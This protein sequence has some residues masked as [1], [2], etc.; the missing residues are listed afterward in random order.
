MQRVVSGKRGD[1]KVQ[2]CMRSRSEWWA[3]K[4]LQRSAHRVRWEQ[5]TTDKVINWSIYCICRLLGYMPVALSRAYLLS[6]TRPAHDSL[7]GAKM[8]WRDIC[9]TTKR[10]TGEGCWTFN[11]ALTKHNLQEFFRWK[12]YS[13]IKW[14]ITLT[15]CSLC[16]SWHDQRQGHSSCSSIC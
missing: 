13:I 7:R 11:F 1:G 16:G 12:E 14:S 3:R 6:T 15:Q 9:R 4:S 5:D 8:S 10:Q 2:N